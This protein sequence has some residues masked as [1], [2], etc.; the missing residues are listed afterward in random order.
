MQKISYSLKKD[1]ALEKVDPHPTISISTKHLSSN[2]HKNYSKFHSFLCM[3]FNAHSS[4]IHKKAREKT[5][6]TN[7]YF[8]FTRFVVEINVH[9]TYGNCE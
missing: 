6:Q 5:H 1:P 2:Q 4:C 9:S 3:H 8:I 7:L